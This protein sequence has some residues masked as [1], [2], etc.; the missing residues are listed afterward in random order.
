MT[1][2]GT[3]VF[4]EL[5]ETE[6]RMVLVASGGETRGPGTAKATLTGVLS[7]CDEGR[8]V[9]VRT[10]LMVTGRPAQFGPRGA[11]GGGRPAV[12]AVRG[13]SGGPAV[14]AERDWAGPDEAAS[15]VRPGSESLDLLRTAGLPVA[16]RA[17]AAAAALADLALIGGWL[18]RRGRGRRRS[19]G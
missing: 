19:H 5:D 2:P 7:A 12:G 1:Y 8:A 15:L 11:G 14:P 9:S 3:A 4:Q 13:V 16:G 6:Y 18:R 10:D 17:A